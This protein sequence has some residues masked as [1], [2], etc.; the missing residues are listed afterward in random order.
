VVYSRLFACT[1]MKQ[2][3][4]SS[5][6]IPAQFTLKKQKFIFCLCILSAGRLISCVCPYQVK[7]IRCIVMPPQWGTHQT[8]HLPTALPAHEYLSDLEP[9]GW[10]HTQPNELPQLSPQVPYTFLLEL[11]SMILH[12]STKRY[13]C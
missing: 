6:I 9:L 11:N 13:V 12:Y 4:A 1:R 10:I 8:V 2:K 5:F 3:R 7:E